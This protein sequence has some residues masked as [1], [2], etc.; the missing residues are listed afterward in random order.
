M[1]IADQM[2]IDYAGEDETRPASL[3]TDEDEYN[4]DVAGYLHLPGV[5]GAAALDALRAAENDAAAALL[6]EHPQV[7]SQLVDIEVILTPR[8]IFCIEIR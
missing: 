2:A 5:L 4:F 8:C 1:S 6:L 7:T 3:L